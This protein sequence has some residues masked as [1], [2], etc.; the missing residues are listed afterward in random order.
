MNLEAIKDQLGIEDAKLRLGD[1]GHFLWLN[2]TR[3][4]QSFSHR[5]PLEPKQHH[6]DAAKEAA[7]QWFKEQNESF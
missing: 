2:I 4:G 7:E 6:I 5:L 3:D 1:N